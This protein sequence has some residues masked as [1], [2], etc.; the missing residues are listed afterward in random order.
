V[1]FSLIIQPIKS[2]TNS[3]LEQGKARINNLCASKKYIIPVNKAVA[4][5][6]TKWTSKSK[7]YS[8]TVSSKKPNH[9]ALNQ[10]SGDKIS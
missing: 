10:Y 2:L 9:K 5:A 1:I 3:G 7:A 4:T 8:Q 6:N